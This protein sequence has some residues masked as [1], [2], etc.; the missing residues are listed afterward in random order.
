MPKENKKSKRDFKLKL[1]PLVARIVYLRL[2]IQEADS[3]RAQELRE[4]MNQ[5][6]QE[7]VEL[8]NEKE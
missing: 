8:F 4:E 2:Q 5:K 1:K 6:Q 7:L 3:D